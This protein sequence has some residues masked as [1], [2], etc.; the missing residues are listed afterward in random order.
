MSDK[1]LRE[2]SRFLRSASPE[3][4]DAF[5]LAFEHYVAALMNEIVRCPP[6]E[7]VGYQGRLQ[8]ATGLLHLFKTCHLQPKKSEPAAQ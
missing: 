2:A 5:I 8:Q 6:A 1:D 3:E 7:L 4:F